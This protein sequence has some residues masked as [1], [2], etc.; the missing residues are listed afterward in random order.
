MGRAGPSARQ[1][2]VD[3][4]RRVLAPVRGGTLSRGAVTGV[5]EWDAR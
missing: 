2:Q 1:H 3:D 4:Y 5:R